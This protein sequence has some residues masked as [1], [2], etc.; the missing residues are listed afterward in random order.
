MLKSKLNKLLSAWLSLNPD[1]FSRG[2]NE[3]FHR[4][5]LARFQHDISVWVA[6]L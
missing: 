3:F 6:F 1:S 2:E 4:N 5:Y